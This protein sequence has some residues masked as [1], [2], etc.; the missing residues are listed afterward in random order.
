[1][2][3][4]PSR[5]IVT[6]NVSRRHFLGGLLSTSA[7]VVAA[8]F[9]P[10]VLFA[11]VATVKSA[12]DSA[13]LNPSVYLGIDPDGTVHIVTH[14][15]EMG[16]GIRTSLPMVAADELDADWARVKIVQGIGD[17]RYGDQNTDG[18]KSIRDFFDAFRHA[19][20]AARGMLIQAA[21]AQWQV[22]ATECET[23]LHEVVHKPSGRRAAYG[24]LVPAA[25]KL[26]VPKPGTLRFKPRSAWRYIGKDRPIY[27]LG[28]IVSG[29]AIFGMD[30]KVDGMLYASIEHPPVLGAT[31]KSVDDKAALK[32][33]GVRQVVTLDPWKPP[34]GFQPLGGVAVIADNTWAAFQGR[35]QLK[36]DWDLGPHASY[37]SASYK[38][39]LIAAV[40]QPGKVARSR[41]NVDAEFAKGGKVVEA[42]Y[43]VP[44]HAHATMEPPVAVAEYRDGKVTAWAPVQNPQAAQDTVAAALGIDK[45]NVVCHVTLLGG[46]FGRKSKPDFVAEAALLSRRVG[47]PVKVVW[48]REDD[49]Q[50][51]YYHAVA[52]VSHKAVVNGRGRP[53]AWLARSAFPPIASTFTAGERYGMDIELGMGLTD[54]PFDVP[55]YRAE[56]C[57]AEAHV[58]I[59]WFRSVANIYQVFAASSFVDELAHAAGRDPLDYQ[60]DLIGPGGVLDL[61]ADGVANYWN[62]GV[63]ADKYPFDTRRLRRV[64]EIA[65]QRAGWAKRSRAKGRGMGIVAARSFTSYIASVVEVQVDAQG[66]VRIP[67]VIQVVDAGTVVNPDRVRSQFEGAAVMGIGLAM[68]GEIS[69]EAGRVIQTNFH[70]F[71][72]PR[73]TDAPAQVDVHIVES[74]AP[75]GGVG[76][77]GLPPIVPALTNAIFAATGKRI[78]EL[79]ISK[80]KLV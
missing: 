6:T 76:E 13:A 71:Q 3:P 78:R 21:A 17:V 74:D 66:R 43:Y 10:D 35:K 39:Q 29:K 57:P 48:S 80:T 32:V 16:T 68:T 40:Q 37:D 23:G 73:I 27:D 5:T 56:N 52:A 62:Y 65:G 4:T 30:A 36:I 41:G 7:F 12:A 45:T 60:L 22:P 15:S 54:L 69:A 58:R 79:P 55:A 26:P 18:S 50:F 53:T 14:R 75:P 1:M 8:R 28:D 63:P 67:R 47:K 2:T 33:R 61:K 59:G 49:L 24:S 77:P 42:V 25:A 44:H 38:K 64:L 70:A 11:Q 34:I 51:D 31:I 20:A 9:V 72:V 19:G 46:G